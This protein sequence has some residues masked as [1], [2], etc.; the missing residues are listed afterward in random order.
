MGVEVELDVVSLFPEGHKLLADGIEVA[1][2]TGKAAG[3]I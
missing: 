1:L 3:L 2:Q